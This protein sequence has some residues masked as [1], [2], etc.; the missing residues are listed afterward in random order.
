VNGR[1]EIAYFTFPDF[2]GRGIATEMAKAL[3]SHAPSDWNRRH[4]ADVAGP[5]CVEQNTRM[6]G[7][8]L[9]G[10]AVDAEVGDVWEATVLGG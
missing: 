5:Q 4:R 6:L 7:F 1:V 9:A 8:T 10:H 3:R 2:E